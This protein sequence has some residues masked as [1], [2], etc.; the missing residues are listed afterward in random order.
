[1]SEIEDRMEIENLQTVF[2]HAADRGDY[3]L[4]RSLYTDDA[5][6]DHGGYS[7]PVDGYIEWV[8]KTHEAYEMLS[9][10]CG[11]PLIR[12]AGDFA[13]SEMKGHVFMRLKGPPA[14]NTFAVTRAFDKYVRT[15]NGWRF[16][17][18][19][20]CGD[21]MGPAFEAQELDGLKGTMDASDPVY[22][23]LPGLVA[24]LHAGFGCK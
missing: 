6:D 9:H 5:V 10:I 14:Q 1:M 16:S 15:A 19:K 4:L 21:W 23:E 2:A 22:S 12:L 13:E 3:A 17:S 20:L 18:R 7:G 8:K 24:A 11:K